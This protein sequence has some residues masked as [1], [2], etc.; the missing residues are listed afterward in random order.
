MALDER[1]DAETFIEFAREQETRI[2]RDRGTA[3]LDA[4]LRVERE[5][6]RFGFSVTHWMMPSA[7][8]RHPEARIFSRAL[9]DYGPVTSPLKLKMQA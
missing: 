4:Q 6:N 2:G 7:P 1:A 3:E 9:S 5:A 8:A